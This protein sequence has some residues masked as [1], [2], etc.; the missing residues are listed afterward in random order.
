MGKNDPNRNS[1]ETS[2]FGELGSGID[3]RIKLQN[4][5][6]VFWSL[7]VWPTPVKI[8][9]GQKQYEWYVLLFF[10]E[11]SFKAKAWLDWI[12]V[13]VWGMFKTAV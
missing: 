2:Y 8:L 9:I 12:R 1:V 13:G 4:I 7:P 11:K 3:W 10:S 6:T 5:L